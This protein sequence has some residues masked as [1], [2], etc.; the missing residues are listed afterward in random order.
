MSEQA[1]LDDRASRGSPRWLLW[2]LL[3]IATLGFGLSSRI[4]A[5]RIGARA[6]LA[7]WIHVL[8]PLVPTVLLLI[9][10]SLSPSAFGAGLGNH[11][12]VWWCYAVWP[13][14]AVLYAIAWNGAFLYPVL[15]S[16]LGAARCLVLPV[17]E[18]LLFRALFYAALVS[19][20]PSSEASAKP[21]SKAVVFSALLFALWGYWGWAVPGWAWRLGRAAIMFVAGLAYGYVRRRSGSV[22]GPIGMHMVWNSLA[23][24]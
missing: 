1:L 17:F 8:S 13:A 6:G 18:E 4:L 19:M 20:Y 9:I 15:L 10:V 24:L 14:V 16:R 22:L 12:R 7:Q 11:R 3:L 23:S 21:L 2:P 5:D